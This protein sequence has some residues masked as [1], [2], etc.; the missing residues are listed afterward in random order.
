M[1]REQN[2]EENDICLLAWLKYCT[3]SK[4]LSESDLRFIEYSI[5]RL[6]KKGIALSY[7]TKFKRMVKL[8]ERLMDKCFVEYKTDPQKQVYIHYRLLKEN[9]PEEYTTE[10]M[11]NV[12]MGIHEKSFVLFYHEILQYYIT[13]ESDGEVNIT[14]SRNLQFDQETADDEESNYY[15]INMMLMA[16]EMQDEK[17]LLDIMEHYVKTQYII[18]KCFLPINQR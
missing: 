9:A 4:D 12:F 17:A 10:R 18:L 8:P 14:E 15:Q 7:F 1:R 3:S 6:E 5:Y 2:Y 11:S 13:E 16:M